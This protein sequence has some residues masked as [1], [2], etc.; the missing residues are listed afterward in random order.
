MTTR[1]LI[2]NV[3]SCVFG[4]QLVGE[5]L[6][7]AGLSGNK[8]INTLDEMARW[9]SAESDGVHVGCRNCDGEKKIAERQ[10][11][12]Q[13][14]TFPHSLNYKKRELSFQESPCPC[15][16]V[17]ILQ[18]SITVPL[19]ME[20]HTVVVRRKLIVCPGIRA[21]LELG[22]IPVLSFVSHQLT[23]FALAK[24]MCAHKLKPV[25]GG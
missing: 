25:C 18:H 4:Y 17:R 1:Q 8:S 6:L 3:K 9:W 7:W 24:W 23:P 11:R 22:E 19:S 16:T 14:L 20:T 15:Y 21:L 13:I 10:P 12:K 2:L 5:N